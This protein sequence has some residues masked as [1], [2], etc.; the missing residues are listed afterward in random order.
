MGTAAERVASD[1]GLRRALE[2]ARS[3][4]VSPSVFNGRQPVTRYQHNHAG[5]LVSSTTDPQ[6]TEDDA[7]LAVALADW[8]ADLCPGCNGSLAETTLAENE[9]RYEAKVAA[10]CHRCTASQQLQGT[11]QSRPTPGALLVSTE[12]RVTRETEHDPDLG[13]G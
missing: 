8:E 7:Q 12:L 1:P 5:Q 3:W 2:A 9:E 4:G 10:R 6:W 11:L 13:A